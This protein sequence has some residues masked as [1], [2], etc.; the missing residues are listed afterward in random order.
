MPERDNARRI[1]GHDKETVGQDV[2]EQDEIKR[3]EK[4]D[5]RAKQMRVTK[6]ISK[7]I[8]TIQIIRCSTDIGIGVNIM[9]W[10]STTWSKSMSL[11]YDYR[12]PLS[13]GAG[14]PE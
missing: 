12:T 2:G 14:A 11:A 5:R 13:A 6:E 4:M 7:A 10:P 3:K 9:C 1:K 8:E